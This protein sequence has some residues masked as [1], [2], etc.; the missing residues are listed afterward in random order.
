MNEPGRFQ[1]EREELVEKW[2]DMQLERQAGVG[3]QRA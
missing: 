1:E 2:E 3:S